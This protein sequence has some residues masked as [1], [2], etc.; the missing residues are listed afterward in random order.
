MPKKSKLDK[1]L[2]FILRKTIKSSIKELAIKYCDLKDIT[3]DDNIRRSISSVLSKEEVSTTS[4][5]V[6]DS[7][8]YK[9]AEK[10][11]ADKSKKIYLVTYA[12]NNTPINKTLLDNMEA[13]AKHYNAEILVNAGVYLNPG[14]DSNKDYATTWH[15]R[16]IP[17][18]CSNDQKLHKYLRIITDANVL[19]TASDPLR[20]F[21]AITGEESSI[22][23]HP[24]QH[25]TTI[26]TLPGQTPKLMFTTGAITNC[27]YRKSRV[28]KKAEFNHSMGF[29]VV[30]VLDKVNFVARH[31]SAK[32]DGSFIDLNTK[33]EGGKITKG[34]FDT[35]ILG[36][37]HLHYE[38]VPM[39][40]EVKKIAKKTKTKHV[41]LH[42]IIDGHSVNNHIA[43]DFI[44][45]A[46]NEK[47]G[48]NN[49]EEEVNYML[50][51]LEGWVQFNPVVVAANHNDR[52]DRVVR[53]FKSIKD[54]KNAFKINQYRQVLLE[55]KA[56]KG[57]I[58]YEIDKHFKGDVITLG[59]NSSFKRKGFELALHGDAA[60]N[61][62]RGGLN[63]FT[64]LNTKIVVAHSH[65][66]ATKNGTYVVGITCHEDHGYNTGI[67]SWMKSIGVINEFG[68]FQHLFYANNNKF[69]NLI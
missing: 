15:K 51:W 10:K 53:S 32:S 36:D 26:P 41:V 16:L 50:R 56:P 18:L 8:E 27:N 40:D 59:R 14:S 23:G 22:I 11:K 57:L 48:L 1:E 17:Y 68:K 60:A 61:G 64:K 28:G 47:K 46:L 13:L 35:I 2:I 62:S 54:I 43:D 69:S 44:H 31:V 42:D 9:K 55:E 38:H 19:P 29:L 49:I 25:M 5:K 30:E 33:V 37:T 63:A 21:E 34:T 24:R 20:G 65:S 58:A 52:F 39:L 7:K 45:Q 66:P 12:Q 67:S 3:Y 4:I 6:K